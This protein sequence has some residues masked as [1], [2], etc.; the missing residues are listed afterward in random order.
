MVDNTI[1]DIVANYLASLTS[2]V[3]R[4]TFYSFNKLTYWGITCET[5]RNYIEMLNIKDNPI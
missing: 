3:T 4:M 2:V 1:T 5:F